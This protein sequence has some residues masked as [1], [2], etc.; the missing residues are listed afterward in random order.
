MDKEQEE[1][2]LEIAARIESFLCGEI[3]RSGLIFEPLHQ[4][5]SNASAIVREP[6]E[7]EMSRVIFAACVALGRVIAEYNLDVSSLVSLVDVSCSKGVGPA[8]ANIRKPDRSLVSRVE[9]LEELLCF[10]AVCPGTIPFFEH[11]RGAVPTA[12]EIARASAL[13]I[14][15]IVHDHELP[16]VSDLVKQTHRGV[17]AGR[18]AREENE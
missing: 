15:G 16:N 18:T 2:L 6:D 4:K 11:A 8:L 14:G 3:V 17:L 9:I 5:A 1:E 7:D 13:A 12:L 10:E